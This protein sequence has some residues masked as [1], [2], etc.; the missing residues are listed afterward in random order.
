MKFLLK[1]DTYESLDWMS[2][3]QEVYI[4]DTQELLNLLPDKIKID[5]GLIKQRMYRGYVLNIY[6]V[7]VLLHFMQQLNHEVAL[8]AQQKASLHALT[9]FF[10]FKVD[11]NTVVDVTTGVIKGN[12]F[13]VKNTVNVDDDT[14]KEQIIEL[15]SWCASRYAYTSNNGDRYKSLGNLFKMS[16]ANLAKIGHKNRHNMLRQQLRQLIRENR[17]K[18]RSDKLAAKI[19]NWIQ[20]YLELGD[21]DAF[22][23]LYKVS[24]TI[25][26]NVPL[27][28]IVEQTSPNREIK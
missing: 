8:K 17:L 12:L 27:Y 15:I 26:T 20:A 5:I 28:S 9:K 2:Q 4:T 3:A 23:N 24:L 11:A 16:R 21:R 22:I 6:T 19:G 1:D 13:L 7:D 25:D 18:I 14:C 10:D